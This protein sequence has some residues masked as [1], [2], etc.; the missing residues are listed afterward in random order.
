MSSIFSTQCLKINTF[1]ASVVT[2]V[3]LKVTVSDS[4]EKTILS[5]NADQ[6]LFCRIV[7]VAKSRDIDLKNVLKHELSNVPLSLAKPVGTLNKG[8][9]SKL[10]I[11]LEKERLWSS[12]NFQ[13][14]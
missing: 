12:K 2:E 9:N 13:Q 11:A 6:H 5:V 3:T 8:I 7:I 1:D 14:R 4:K 10:M